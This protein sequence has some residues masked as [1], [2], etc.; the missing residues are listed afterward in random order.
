M[1]TDV[2]SRGRR[3]ARAAAALGAVTVAGVAATGTA[4][5]LP[6]ATQDRPDQVRGAQVHLVYAVPSDRVDRGLDHSGA[7]GGSA[8]SAQGW[9]ASQTSG[10]ALRLDTFRGEPDVTFFRMRTTDAQAAARGPYVREEIDDQLEAAGL[11]RPGKLYAVFY[12]GTSTVSC[13]SGSW[14]PENPDRVVGLYLHA[15]QESYDC[16]QNRLRGAS[17]GAGFWE[18]V[19]MHELMHGLGFV[20]RCAPH[21]VFDGHSSD[22]PTDLMYAGRLGWEPGVLDIGRD[23]YFGHRNR[24]CADL[25]RSRFLVRYRRPGRLTSALATPFTR[26]ATAHGGP[27]PAP[28]PSPERR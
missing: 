9:L 25:R 1:A 20:A 12:D 2:R 28:H 26:L 17:E 23:D 24:G 8:W 5:A 21:H 27:W 15:R 6:R 19:L 18:L 14:P 7:V 4:W 11:V 3:I 13:G 22:G 16:G 10:R